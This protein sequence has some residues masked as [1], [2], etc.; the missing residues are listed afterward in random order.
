[1]IDEMMKHKKRMKS[2]VL[3]EDEF[4]LEKLL[5]DPLCVITEKKVDFAAK[6]LV[7]MVYIEWTE[8]IEEE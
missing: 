1:M 4:M 5:N 3:P 2:F 7:Y 6:E 8:Y